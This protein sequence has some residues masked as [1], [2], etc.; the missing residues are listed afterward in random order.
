MSQPNNIGTKWTQQEEAEL[1]EQIGQNL[2]VDEISTLHGRNPGGISSKIYG[3]AYRMLTK[4]GANFEEVALKLRITLE[5]MDEFKNQRDE[6][7]SKKKAR[8]QER[9]S[10]RT[11]ASKTEQ[12]K[13]EQPKAEQPKPETKKPSQ[14]EVLLEIRDLLKTLTQ[15]KRR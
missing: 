3:I 9:S 12:P 7:I 14:M 2:T 8:R 11:V 5:Q 4:E 13:A 15:Q 1:I 10:E 6:R